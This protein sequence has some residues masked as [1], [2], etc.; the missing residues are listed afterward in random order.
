MRMMAEGR[1]LLQAKLEDSELQVKELSRQ[2]MALERAKVELEARNRQLESAA[3]TGKDAPGVGNAGPAGTPQVSCHRR[4][5]S[6]VSVLWASLEGLPVFVWFQSTPPGGQ[7]LGGQAGLCRYS[8]LGQLAGRWAAQQSSPDQLVQWSD[9]HECMQD[10]SNPKEDA[11]Y[12]ESLS[13]FVTKV[14]LVPPASAKPAASSQIFM[15]CILLVHLASSTP[16]S[17]L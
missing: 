3:H 6:L 17:L 2:V 13:V 4:L 14:C 15:A 16:R 7:I 8:G 11:A 9:C 12:F 5:F 1:L 10:P